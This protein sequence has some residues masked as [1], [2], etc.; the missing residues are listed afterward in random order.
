MHPVEDHCPNFC[1]RFPQDFANGCSFGR[2]L[3]HYGMQPDFDKFVDTRHPDAMV[4]NYTRLQT[5]FLKLGVKFDTRTANALMREEAGVALRLL[6]S[7]K[8]NLGQVNKGVQVGPR[9]AH[10][11]LGHACHHCLHTSHVL[12]AKGATHLRLKP[13]PTPTSML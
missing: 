6:Y 9:D 13:G 5:S 2:L 8:Q 1:L 7:L 12:H 11:G 3:Q 4:N 10:V